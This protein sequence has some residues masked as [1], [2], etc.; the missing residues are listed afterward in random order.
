M[1]D[2]EALARKIDQID[3]NTTETRRILVESTVDR[4]SVLDVQR[5]HS[6]QISEMGEQIRVIRSTD[7][8]TKCVHWAVESTIKWGTAGL[9]LLLTRGLIVE[10]ITQAQKVANR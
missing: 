3:A 2:L 7:L 9:L 4:P 5:K 1:H 6:A 8:W 10:I